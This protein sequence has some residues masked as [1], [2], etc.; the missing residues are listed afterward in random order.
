VNITLKEALKQASRVLS[1][2]IW[3]RT[4]NR[5]HVDGALGSIKNEALGEWLRDDSFSRIG[6]LREVNLVTGF[7]PTGLL[8]VLI[9]SNVYRATLFVNHKLFVGASSPRESYK[10][11]HI[12]WF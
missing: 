2:F 6:L 1:G 12:I 7:T 4:E 8:P 3:L 5:K 9:L 11:K 10:E